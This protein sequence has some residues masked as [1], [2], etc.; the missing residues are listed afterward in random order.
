MNRFLIAAV[1]TAAFIAPA[2]AQSPFPDVARQ[3]NQKIVKIFGAGGLRG[4]VAYG[5]AITIS[6]DGFA[7]TAA[8]H[9]LDTTEL[10]VHLFDGRRAVA[11]VVVID[12]EHDFQPG[13]T[14]PLDPT[15]SLEAAPLPAPAPAPA[16]VPAS[17]PS[18]PPAPPAAT[19]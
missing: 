17:P 16:P 6:P 5:S 4:L 13:R 14:L 3:V 1:A 7:L 15:Q 9:L 10:R 18:A 8:S 19:K 12:P 2:G 11:K